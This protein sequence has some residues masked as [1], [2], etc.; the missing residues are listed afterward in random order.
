VYVGPKELSSLEAV[1]VPTIRNG[2]P[3]LRG[4]VDFGWWGLISRPAV[5]VAEVDVQTC[6]SQLGMGD[7]HSDSDHH[8]CAA[9][10]ADHADEVDAEDAAHRAADQIDPGKI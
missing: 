1:S 10:A 7:C 5:P 6:L 8:D 3:D 4:T 2:D 9:A